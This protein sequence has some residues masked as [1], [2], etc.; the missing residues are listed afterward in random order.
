MASVNAILGGILPSLVWLWFWLQEDKL[1]PE[2]RGKLMLAFLGGM[3]A[4][5]LAYPLETLIHSHFELR[6]QTLI[7]WAVVEEVLKY[8]AAYVLVLRSKANN[9]PID[10]MMY[11]ITVALG[12]AALEN[13]FFILEPLV[14]GSV[15]EGI[16]TGNLR[17]L[18]SSLLH[19]VCSGILGYCIGREFFAKRSL[20]IGWVAIGLA[21]AIALHAVFNASII[22]GSGSD[23]ILAFSSVWTG[24]LIVLILF[25]KIKKQ[26][27]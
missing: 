8:V 23:T 7:L 27:Y 3:G 16:V 6:P 5:I 18:G 2:P 1:H 12:F 10:A 4:V 9:E 22:Y 17:F 26:T 15:A 11:L 24:A 20:R 14:R 13:T 19:L 21:I 25:E